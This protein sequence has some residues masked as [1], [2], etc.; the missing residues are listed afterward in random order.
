MID[1]QV[2]EEPI[3]HRIEANFPLPSVPIQP[4]NK[5]KV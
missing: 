2:S 5:M 4:S 1:D 3:V